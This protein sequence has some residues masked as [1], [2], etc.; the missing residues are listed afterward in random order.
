[1]LDPSVAVAAAVLNEPNAIGSTLGLLGDE[2]T[3]L[4]VRGAFEGARRYSDWKTRLPISDAVLTARLQT[5]VD[6]AVLRR[7]HAE[8]TLTASGL[9]LWLLLLCIW[10]WEQRQVPQGSALPSMVHGGCGSTFHPVL[11]CGACGG[12]AR[13]DDVDARFSPGGSFERSAPVGTNRRRVS[14][15]RTLLAGPGMFA[16]TMAIIGSRWSSAVLGAAFLGATR[17]RDFEQ[18]GAPPSVLSERLRSFVD[19]DVLQSAANDSAAYQL[20]AKGRAFFPVVV[21]FLVWGERWRPAADGPAVLASHRSCGATFVPEWCCSE[22]GNA[23][24]RQHVGIVTPRVGA[25]V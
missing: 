14:S 21:A 2:W 16:D 8:Y 1:V 13:I 15:A 25:E 23:L 18:I 4:I 7:E 5:L 17:F 9:D 6:A 19:L 11:Q 20:T 3:L 24:D 10:D 12:D 22:C